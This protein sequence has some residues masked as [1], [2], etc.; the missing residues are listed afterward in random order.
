MTDYKLENKIRKEKR[1]KIS[2]SRMY[3]WILE[4]KIL[5]SANEAKTRSIPDKTSIWQ[6]E[7]IVNL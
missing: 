3:S 4:Q 6:E 1:K 5:S 7:A 2:R